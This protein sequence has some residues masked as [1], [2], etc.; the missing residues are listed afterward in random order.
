MYCLFFLKRFKQIS[1]RQH[2]I[3]FLWSLSKG[4]PLYLFLKL[5]TVNRGHCFWVGN[6]IAVCAH[7]AF[8]GW[9][10][11]VHTRFFG[12]LMHRRISTGITEMKHLK[13]FTIQQYD[14][15]IS[16][17]MGPSAHIMGE[18]QRIGYIVTSFGEYFTTPKWHCVMLPCLFVNHCIKRV[19]LWEIQYH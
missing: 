8:F 7:S 12:I 11:C 5:I 17:Y 2:F 9:H 3:D 13:H 4:V 16:I 19:N 10:S 15:F 1:V 18:Q 6:V 14:W